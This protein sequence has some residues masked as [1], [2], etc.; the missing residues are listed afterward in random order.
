MRTWQR[1]W[2]F[3]VVGRNDPEIRTTARGVKVAQFLLATDRQWRDLNGQPKM[4]REWH[5]V[6]AW[7][8]PLKVANLQLADFCEQHLHA[9]DHVW[10][11][12]RVEYRKYL[13]RRTGQEKWVTEIIATEIIPV[14]MPVPEGDPKGFETVRVPADKFHEPWRLLEDGTELAPQA[15]PAG[16]DDGDL[17]PYLDED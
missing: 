1:W 6:V 17:D 9:G 8:A 15:V 13:D 2:A 14:A 16:E 3:G 11:E 10:L 4:K 12:G 7:N 5:R